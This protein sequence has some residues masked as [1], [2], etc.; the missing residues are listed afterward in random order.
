MAPGTRLVG[1]TAQVGVKLARSLYSRWRVLGAE[2]RERLEPQAEALKKSA[3]D[4]RGYP[5]S[6]EAERELRSASEEMAGAIVDSAE[7][8]P[9]VSEIE[10]RRLKADL[11]RELERL[12]TADI[13]ASRAPKLGR[14]D[15]SG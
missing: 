15:T 10:V 14:A 1:A 6:T 9:E 8:D 7:N 2:D 5:D 11:Q 13:S 12:A 3:L 4:L